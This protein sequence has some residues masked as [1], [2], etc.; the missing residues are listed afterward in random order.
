MDTHPLLETR[1]LRV[2][3]A[4]PLVVQVAMMTLLRH[5]EARWAGTGLLLLCCAAVVAVAVGW[6]RRGPGR[7]LVA[8]IAVGSA[9]ALPSSVLYLSSLDPGGADIPLAGVGVWFLSMVGLLVTVLAAG[10]AARSDQV[11]RA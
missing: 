11:S 7:G 1:S 8:G 9:I 10:G 6:A 4:L 3:A 5:G 2:T